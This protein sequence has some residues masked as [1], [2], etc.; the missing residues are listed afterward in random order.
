MAFELLKTLAVLTLVLGLIFLLAYGAKR[1]GLQR[2]QPGA[3]T[4]GWRI[5]AVKSL[6]PRRQVF[7]VEVGA[8]IVLVGVTD[9]M[10]T[11]LTEITD[12][13]ERQLVIAGVTK[14]AQSSNMFAQ[15][16]KKAEA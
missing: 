10:M 7:M 5:L 13:A 6:G 15:F 14:P 9:K 11:P 3:G 8:R 16:L 4:G 2:E 1:F 12:D